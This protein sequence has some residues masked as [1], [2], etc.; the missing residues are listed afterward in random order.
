MVK[1]LSDLAPHQSGTI[2]KVGCCG[3][4]R[5]RM[6]DMGLVTGV[7]VEVV[8]FAPLGDPLELNVKGYHLSLRK[9]EARGIQVQVTE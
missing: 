6:L 7:E 2:I 5:R 9:E 8:R 1:E 3:K 4:A